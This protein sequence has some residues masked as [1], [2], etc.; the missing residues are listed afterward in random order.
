MD[1]LHLYF[2]FFVALLFLRGQVR[3]IHR[4]ANAR[5]LGL[6]RETEDFRLEGAR[7]IRLAG[8]FSSYAS[9]H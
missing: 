1:N 6:G 7:E 8:R 3:P 9:P 2:L 5:Q 4:L